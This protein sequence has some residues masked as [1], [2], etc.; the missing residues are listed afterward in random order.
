[1]KPDT[2]TTLFIALLPALLLGGCGGGSRQGTPDAAVSPGCDGSCASASTFLTV[3]DVERVLAQGIVEAQTRGV[4]ATFAVTDRVGNVLAVYRM[5]GANPAG[6]ELTTNSGTSGGLEGIVLPG[7][8]DTLAAIAKAVTGAYLSS[9][10][11]AFS[12]RTAG[13]IVQDHF[14]PGEDF[15][16]AG[17]LFGVQFSQLAC[18]DLTTSVADGSFGPKQSPL[19]LSADP[20]GFPLYKNG[21]VVGGVGVIA[22]G[23]YSLDANILDRDHNLDELIAYAAAFSYAAPAD[24]RA[25]RITADGKTLRFSDVD[26]GDLSSS[27]NSAPAFASFGVGVG[28]LAAVPGYSAGA[29]IAGTAFGQPASGIRADGGSFADLDAF[30]LVNGADAPRFAPTAGTDGG[31]ALTA[32]EVTAILRS[33]VNVANK[34]RAQIRQPLGSQARVTVSVV[35][36]N[37]VVLGILRTRDAPLFGTDVSLQKARTAAFFSSDQTA[38]LLAA[39]PDAT[40]LNPDL[41]AGTTVALNDYVADTRNFLGLP[42]LLADGEFA[43][44]NRSIGNLARPF[45]PDGINGNNHGPLGKPAGQASAFSTGFQLDLVYN[46]IIQHVAFAAGLTGTDVS[47][48][49]AGKAALGGADVALGN[50]LG[51]NGVQIFPGSM[52]IYRGDTLVGAIGVSGDGVDQ[53]DMI[54]FLGLHEAGVAVANAPAGRR[55]DQLTPQGVRLRYVQCPQSPFI[56]SDAQNVCAGK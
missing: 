30:V 25:D 7:A 1:M 3:N 31:S 36:S 41:S 12:T 42:N 13:Q 18:S 29:I 49:C 45:F 19:G 24:R 14:N 8:A 53:D 20:G 40:Y 23:E 37:G 55:A 4:P 38:T 34:S 6:V 39:V 11:N 33:A 5:T 15:Q 21:S 35:D 43:F 51:A 54:A 22:D 17:P 26:S 52:P 27:P 16:P 28:G 47:S 32:N 48:G 2:R 44:A 56:N 50:A 46:G 9:E 10:G